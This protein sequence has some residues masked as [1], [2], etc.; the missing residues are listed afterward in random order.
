MKISDEET[1]LLTDEKEP[2]Q[3]AK[4]LLEKGVKLVAVTLG[5][6]GSYIA[7]AKW[8]KESSRI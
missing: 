6:D 1:E 2:E 8:G 7:N 5:K 3:A 4:V